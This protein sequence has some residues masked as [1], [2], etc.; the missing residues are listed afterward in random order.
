M[1]SD[2]YQDAR[3]IPPR[4]AAASFSGS[5]LT[6]RWLRLFLIRFDNFM[7][8]IVEE[9]WEGLE[10]AEPPDQILDVRG[11]MFGHKN[12]ELVAQIN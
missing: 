1:D 3:R 10:D 8:L 9:E 5:W 6:T 12:V 7:L 11:P 4:R 2:P